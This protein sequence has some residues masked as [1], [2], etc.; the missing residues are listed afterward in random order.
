MTDCNKIHRLVDLMEQKGVLRMNDKRLASILNNLVD[1][2]NNGSK[3][4]Q[5]GEDVEGLTR[6][7]K[8]NRI[9]QYNRPRLEAGVIREIEI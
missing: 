9:S 5:H 1:D 7:V 8:I 4:Y 3:Q 6:Q 2:T